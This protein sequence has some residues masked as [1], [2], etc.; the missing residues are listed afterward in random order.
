[1]SA[2]TALHYFEIKKGMNAII[3]GNKNNEVVI[4]S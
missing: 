2:P 3:Y 4:Y 1:M